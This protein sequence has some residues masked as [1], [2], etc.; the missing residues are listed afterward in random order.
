MGCGGN[1]MMHLCRSLF[2]LDFYDGV[3]AIPPLQM[4][5]HHIVTAWYT[6]RAVQCRAATTTTCDIY[7]Y[8]LPSQREK[9]KG[10]E[11]GEKGEGEKKKKQRQWQWVDRMTIRADLPASSKIET[12]ADKSRLNSCPVLVTHS[13]RE[14]ICSVNVKGDCAKTV[15]M[16]NDT[17][18]TA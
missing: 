7:H 11:K 6:Q 18:T 14:D 15:E 9:K 8:F 10:L 17:I 1:V 5:E 16:S 2:L 4:V 12:C 3:F 13:L